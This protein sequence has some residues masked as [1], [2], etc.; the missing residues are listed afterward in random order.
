MKKLLVITGL[1]TSFGAYAINFDVSITSCPAPATAADC[2]QMEND[3]ESQAQQDLPETSL[4]NYTTGVSNSVAAASKD[5][6]DHSDR[7]NLLSFKYSPLGV[8]FSGDYSDTDNPQVMD[9]FGLQGS[10]QIGVNLDMIPVD[11]VGPVELKKLDL[12]ASIFSLKKTDTSDDSE[13]DAEISSFGLFARYHLYEGKD[14]LPGY[15]AEWGGIFIHTGF[16]KST[17]KLGL[18][19]TLDNQTSSAGGADVEFSDVNA[20]FVMNSNITSIPIEIST[21][22]RLLYVFT[23]YGGLGV[24]INSGSTDIDFNMS[25]SILNSAD[26]SNIGAVSA[27]DSSSGKPDSFTTRAFAGFQFNIP[28]VRLYVQAQKYI[29]N[30]IAAVNAGLK[31]LY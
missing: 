26:S 6:S 29:G 31:I 25:G 11:K 14:F 13:V 1:M 2:A 5:N 28:F 27:D 10:M 8:G 20:S 16:R 21:Y 15:M 7:F 19:T 23:F 9:G 22:M 18:S 24:D 17:M 30:D 12:F 4:G 3:L